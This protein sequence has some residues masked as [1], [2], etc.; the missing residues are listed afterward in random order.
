MTATITKVAATIIAPNGSFIGRSPHDDIDSTC[1]VRKATDIDTA[2]QIA[3]SRRD[4]TSVLLLTRMRD[5]DSTAD[6]I[7]S[8]RPGTNRNGTRVSGDMDRQVS[9]YGKNVCNGKA[10]HIPTIIECASPTPLETLTPDFHFVSNE[11]E[12]LDCLN[13]GQHL[14]EMQEFRVN[15][16]SD[17]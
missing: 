3:S 8:R 10:N 4:W 5:V 17:R 11:I 6:E 14:Q 16:A 1:T 15:L 13:V 9:L 12:I 2:Y 7:F